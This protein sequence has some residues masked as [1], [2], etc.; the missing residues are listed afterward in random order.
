VFAKFKD[1]LTSVLSSLIVI[2]FGF[3]LAE[4]EGVMS[5]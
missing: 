4:I 2:E 3:T 1:E 5:L